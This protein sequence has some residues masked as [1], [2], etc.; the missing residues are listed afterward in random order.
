MQ[1]S[2]VEERLLRAWGGCRCR[3][4]GKEEEGREKGEEEKTSNYKYPREKRVAASRVR[5][6]AN[7]SS[8]WKEWEGFNGHRTWVSRRNWLCLSLCLR[9]SLQ[10]GRSVRP[11]LPP[12]VV[13]SPLSSRQAMDAGM[14]MRRKQ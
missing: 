11:Q 12:S 7:K 8:N 10:R 1:K 2:R 5:A 3:C 4:S 6:G 14:G 9:S 13:G